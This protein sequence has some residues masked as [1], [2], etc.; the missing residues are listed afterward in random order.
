MNLN[1]HALS[2]Y[3]AL[4]RREGF[5]LKSELPE[6]A[7]EERITGLS[8]D[9]REARPGTL[10]ICKGAHFS[11]EYLKEALG[12]G[13]AGYVSET[14]YDGADAADFRRAD[15]QSPAVFLVKDMRAALAALANYF[16]GDIWK[17]LKIIGITGT[18]GKSSTAYY[19][20]FILDD[21]LAAQGKKPCAI[22]SGIDNDDGVIREESH[23]T[24][25][26]TLELH[27]HFK[28]A[29]DSGMEYLCMEVS[30]QAL[31]YERTR[32]MVFE[33]AC[34]LNIG[35][36]HISAIEH[37]DYEDYF[38]SKLRIFPQ[39]RTACVNLE[40]DGTERILRAAGASS[41]LVTFGLSD[42]ADIFAC[43]IR[44][45]EE[46][47][48][49]RVRGGGLD[50]E[51]A[52]SMTGLFNVENALAAMSAASCL[53][54]PP[55]HVAAGLWAAKVSGRMEVYW[56][57]AGKIVIVDYAHNYMSF[58]TLFKS[59]R[60]EYPDRRVSIVFGCPGKK[61]LGRRKEL[62]TLA[63]IYADEVYLTE[64]DAGEEDVLD[65]CRDINKYVEA[66]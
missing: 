58:E 11:A 31:K 41:G 43:D 23:L 64:E 15:G 65:I 21:W 38:S 49:F 19:V 42:A 35:E 9:S 36:D 55:Q 47:I 18:K 22:L 28:N 44:S 39:C 54:V 26:E 27:R 7:A 40:S 2:E 29:V 24:T 4:L 1:F 10:F 62:G 14:A 46:G 52:I 17:K 66:G 25:P 34:F 56:N 8:Y 63:G 32:G 20:K 12:R 5:L 60:K 53:G 57:A 37:S 33:A 6:G 45:S 59:V 30:S 61:A 50:G 16:Y 48:R 3:E 51:Y 13:A